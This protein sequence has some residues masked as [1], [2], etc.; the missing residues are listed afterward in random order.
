MSNSRIIILGR[1]QLGIGL[2]LG[3]SGEREREHEDD[4]EKGRLSDLVGSVEE[5]S[6]RG[7]DEESDE[8]DCSERYSWRARWV[9]VRV[10]SGWQEVSTGNRVDVK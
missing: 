1:R 4:Q 8:G 5:Q 3:T 2:G 9:R 6:V 10:G 7:V